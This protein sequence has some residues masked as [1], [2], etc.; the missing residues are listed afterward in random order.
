MIIFNNFFWKRYLVIFVLFVI[1]K[2]IRRKRSPLSVLPLYSITYWE[3]KRKCQLGIYNYIFDTFFYELTN[4]DF[5]F[6]YCFSL[7]RLM[8]NLRL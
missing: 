8:K 4:A 5:S 7:S 3:K 6:L 2:N 1:N